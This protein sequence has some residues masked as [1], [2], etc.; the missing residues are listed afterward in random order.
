MKKQLN[1][2][3]YTNRNEVKLFP[4]KHF[5]TLD[6]YIIPGLDKNRAKLDTLLT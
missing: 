4:E 1:G 3:L 6:I 2:K 5:L